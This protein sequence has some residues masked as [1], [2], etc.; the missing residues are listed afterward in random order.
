MEVREL[1]KVVLQDG[2]KDC[3]VCCLLSIIRYYGG[4]VSKE[5]LRELTGTT[6][7]GVSCYQLLEAAR[8]VGFSGEGVKG[9]VLHLDSSRLPCIAHII[10]QK[11]YQHFVVIYQMDAKKKLIT[12][13]DPAKGKVC[14]SYSEFQMLSSGYFLYLIPVKTLPIFYEKKTLSLF[15]KSFCKEYRFFLILILISSLFCVFS[16]LVTA[17]HFQYLA[18]YSV[19]GSVISSLITISLFLLL[20]YLNYLVFR[21]LKNFVFIKLS[22]LFDEK[23]IFYVYQQILLLPYLFFKNR[24]LGEVVERV[25]D[26]VKV[27]NF[28]LQ[29]FTTLVTDFLLFLL[30]SF[31][32]F[33]IHWGL[34]VL[35]LSYFFLSFGLG[36]FLYFTKKKLQKRIL[37]KGDFVQSLF[38]ETIQNVDTV[39]GLH[40]EY[41]FLEQL[42]N[43]Y[44]TYL[45]RGYRLEKVLL[46]EDSFKQF[47]YYFMYLCFYGL[48]A[49]LLI[50]KELVVTQFF[51]C[52]HIFHYL[53]GC[54]ERFLSFFFDSYQIP[55]V[56]SR[57]QDLFTLFRENYDGGNYYQ[58]M[59]LDGD[60]IF[61]NLSFKYSSLSLFCD[62]SLIIP[63]GSKVL[64]TGRSGGGKS[65][66]VKILMRYLEV[67]Y[68]MVR[69]GNFDINHIHLELLR[70][71]ISYVTGGELLFSNTLLYNIT[72]NRDVDQEKLL[73]VSR[74]V[75]LEELIEKLPLGY[76][77]IVEENGFNFSSGE[78]QKILLAR[79]LLKNSDIYIFDE[80]FHQIDIGQ[81]GEI[82][83]NIF[84]YLENKTVIVIS[85][86]LQ[87]LELY[88]VRYRLEKGSI[89]EI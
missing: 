42:K 13:M 79:A 88:D 6:K 70:S 58:L 30:F 49:Y 89:Y 56:I 20:Y 83:K 3:G 84:S 53:I 7:S 65:S 69:I 43:E 73:E 37:V 22:L 21:F 18:D 12:L 35:F 60:I 63:S 31:L 38:I 39:K 8:N 1:L 52:Q 78:R 51:I 15:I 66:L 71:R 25:Q 61:S 64:L 55:F 76:Q 82:L 87:H 68:G 17:F 19:K 46:L 32:L 23:L 34:L 4:D 75:L 67:P 59:K 86:R 57:I 62:F 16:Q 28:I 48:G 14:L 80:A 33:R 54:A 9:D 27:K 44:Q 85:H 40:L 47:F 2:N 36:I 45:S 5:Y 29:L 50:Q 77:S 26:V 11:K 24:T 74:L 72:L 81:E 41:D 10:Y